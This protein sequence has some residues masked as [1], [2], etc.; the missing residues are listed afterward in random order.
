MSAASTPAKA[1]GD[2]WASTAANG[3]PPG[4]T[5]RCRV[6][7][8]AAALEQFAIRQRQAVYF[9]RLFAQA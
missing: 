9:E 8:S 1:V 7:A 3:D 6:A 4:G 5:L 2:R